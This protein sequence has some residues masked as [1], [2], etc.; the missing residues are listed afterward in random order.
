M[1]GI[2]TICVIL[3]VLLHVLQENNPINPITIL[4]VWGFNL[5]FFG[6]SR[7]LMAGL[8]LLHL[9]SLTEPENREALRNRLTDLALAHGFTGKT[10]THLT[11]NKR[12]DG[13]FDLSIS[14]QT[15]K[16]IIIPADDPRLIHLIDPLFGTRSRWSLIN[17]NYVGENLE[18]DDVSAHQIL[19]SHHTLKAPPY[20]PQHSRALAWS[21]FFPKGKLDPITP[22]VLA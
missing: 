3:P 17:S 18:L 5:W 11:Y 2:I 10:S 8:T 13:P 21:R 22:K 7:F 15:G 12:F 19:Q 16:N 4:L 20:K 9:D 6:Y 14:D 1:T